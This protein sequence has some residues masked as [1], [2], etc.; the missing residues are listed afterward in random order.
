M[1]NTLKITKMNIPTTAKLIA[2]CLLAAPA[3]SGCS[4]ED[5]NNNPVLIYARGND[6]NTTTGTIVRTPSGT[7]IVTL[8]AKFICSATR[9]VPSDETVRL[10]VDN[11]LVAGYNALHGTGYLAA[12]E[13][14]YA[15]SHDAAAVI[16]S[17]QF[18]SADTV[19]LT[20]TRPEDFAEGSYLLPVTLTPSACRLSS[21]LGVIYV[22]VESR[23]SHFHG[24]AAVP[25]G[26]LVNPA[27]RGWTVTADKGTNPAN[28][29]TATRSQYWN[30]GNNNTPAT[31]VVDLKSPQTLKGIK[32]SAYSTN[33]AMRELSMQWSADSAAWHALGRETLLQPVSQSG[34]GIQ[35]IEFYAP[36]GAQYLK[37]TVEKPWNTQVV[38]S[39]FSIIVE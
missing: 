14:S 29:F 17:G 21:N 33:Y 2:W 26:T 34:Y 12:P 27:G 13:G 22:A 7:C 11:A 37:W 32:F 19:T 10:H 20:L 25:A 31:A 38:I 15:F 1:L 8:D 6:R 3:F 28:M 23:M 30:I 16:K 24:V 35:F 4:E 5:E 36:V 39:M 18:H 9:E